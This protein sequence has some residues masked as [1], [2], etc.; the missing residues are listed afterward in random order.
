MFDEASLQDTCF[1][2]GL[3]WRKNMSL[4]QSLWNIL[5]LLWNELSPLKRSTATFIPLLTLISCYFF[6]VNVC[7]FGIS[8]HTRTFGLLTFILQSTAHPEEKVLS[9]SDIHCF[10]IERPFLGGHSPFKKSLPL[11]RISSQS[12]VGG[13]TSSAANFIKP[14]KES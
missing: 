3:R 6:Q 4:L 1:P 13:R 9:K 2:L 7:D 8:F 14:K 5:A 11:T 12:G 10:T